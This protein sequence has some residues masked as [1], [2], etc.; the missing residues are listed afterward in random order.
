VSWGKFFLMPDFGSDDYHRR[1]R[2]H[3][4]S[5][6]LREKAADHDARIG[7]LARENRELKFYVAGL[8]QMLVRKGALEQGDVEELVRLVER[9]EQE[10]RQ[11]DAEPAS[12]DLEAIAAAARGKK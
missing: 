2:S 3:H 11:A 4:Q 10:A 8:M 5:S 6:F 9:A 1:L 12:A 7:D